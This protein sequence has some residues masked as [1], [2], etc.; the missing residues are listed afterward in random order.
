MLH[1]KSFSVVVQSCLFGAL[2]LC[3]MPLAQA[4]DSRIE[5]K[6]DTKPQNTKPD[7]RQPQQ[8]TP[9]QPSSGTEPVDGD[10][11]ALA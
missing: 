9:S 4:T 10:D 11:T 2:S 1:K 5:I 6:T 8:A 3:F 7:T